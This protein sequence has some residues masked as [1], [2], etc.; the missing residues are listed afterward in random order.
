ME[1][2]DI[3]DPEKKQIVIIGM[4]PE[5]ELVVNTF[6]KVLYVNQSADSDLKVSFA[7]KSSA[8]LAYPASSS[9]EPESVLSYIIFE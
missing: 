1:I 3:E 6:G 9:G 4:K 8:S 7:G 5:E 2:S